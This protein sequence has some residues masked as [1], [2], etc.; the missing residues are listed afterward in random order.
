MTEETKVQKGLNI[1]EKRPGIRSD[2]LAK[3]MGIEAKNLNPMLNAAVKKRFVV[4][5]T[6]HRPGQPDTLEWRLS[7]AVVAKDWDEWKNRREPDDKPLAKDN[8]VHRPVPALPSAKYEPPA[9]AAP[10]AP[11]AVTT[12]AAEQQQA[13]MRQRQADQDA[14]I[15]AKK[16]IAE[17]EGEGGQLVASLNTLR[18]A[19]ADF[20]RHTV[21][22]T[23][24][25]FTPD[26][27]DEC[28]LLI[29]NKINTLAARIETLELAVDVAQQ[30]AAPTV[31]A[32]LEQRTPAGFLVARPK[33]PLRRFTKV[34]SAQQI[35]LGAVRAGSQAEVF[36]LHPVGKAVRGAEW[37]EA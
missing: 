25:K 5:A 18:N 9:K 14:L 22:L 30:Q 26:S 13:L 29:T 7:S 32:S 27:L 20:C 33:K 4:T 6:I 12:P 35:A 2:D 23:G 15:L 17:L 3:A 19:V 34:E 8:A 11:V 28:R 31:D 10:V 1:I 21:A 16:R 24:E 36:A 37:K